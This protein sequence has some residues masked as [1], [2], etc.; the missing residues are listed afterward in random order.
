[1]TRF[2]NQQSRDDSVET[3]QLYFARRAE[4]EERAAANSRNEEIA[5]VH[6][7][8]A[9]TYAEL[10]ATERERSIRRRKVPGL[11]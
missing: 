5:Q 9:S 7:K 3:D 2:Q 1:M 6:R 8:L 4:E 11:I 10:A